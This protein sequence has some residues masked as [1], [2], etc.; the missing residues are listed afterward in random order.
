MTRC[1]QQHLEIP[2]IPI[3]VLAIETVGYLPIISKGNRWSLTAICLHKSYVFVILMK[4]K[5]AES[6]V[7]AYLCAICSQNGRSVVILSDN[8]TK[9]KKGPK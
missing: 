5:S 9:F 8:D 4:E 1:P 7:Q 6:V 2:Q 3:S